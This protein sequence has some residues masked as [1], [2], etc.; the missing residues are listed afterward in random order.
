MLTRGGLK[1]I[2]INSKESGISNPDVY[3]RF[4]ARNLRL[5]CGY[6]KRTMSSTDVQK[7]NAKPNKDQTTPNQPLP[8]PMGLGIAS[9]L[10]ASVLNQ[11]VP[12]LAVNPAQVGLQYIPDVDDNFDPE[13]IFSNG[14]ILTFIQPDQKANENEIG[15]KI[16]DINPVFIT[17]LAH[18]YVCTWGDSQIDGALAR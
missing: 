3:A 4:M 18:I 13:N 14:E 9:T 12:P 5:D 6:Y 10:N 17:Y 7:M 8:S 15:M 2:Q 11:M 1:I 16:F